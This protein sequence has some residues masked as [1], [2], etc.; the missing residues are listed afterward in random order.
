MNNFLVRVHTDDDQ[1]RDE[2]HN[3]FAQNF[4]SGDPPKEA[5]HESEKWEEA[6]R[7]VLTEH[8]VD[9]YLTPFLIRS[10]EEGDP[11]NCVVCQLDVR[12]GKRG[13]VT[14]N[15]VTTS[16]HVTTP[17]GDARSD[18]RTLLVQLCGSHIYFENMQEEG[19]HVKTNQRGKKFRE[20]KIKNRD[21]LLLHG[22]CNY[23][24][25]KGL[26][27][28]IR[29]NKQDLESALNK[30]EGSFFL[31]YIDY[32]DEQA[33][34][35][36][37]NDAW[38]MKSV[39]FFYE[40]SSVLLTNS[41]GLFI[42]HHFNFTKGDGINYLFDNSS[43][44]GELNLVHHDGVFRTDDE[45]LPKWSGSPRR[46][47]Q[48]EQGNIPPQSII[49]DKVG[50]QI[51]P[52]HI[53]SVNIFEKGKITLNKITKRNSIYTK[54]TDWSNDHLSVEENFHRICNFVEG[55][56]FT[57]SGYREEWALLK[58]TIQ[59]SVK[60]YIHGDADKRRDAQTML[61]N[62]FVQTYMKLLRGVIERK[63]EEVFPNT[64]DQSE[65]G[66]NHLN[67]AGEN[68]KFTENFMQNVP[69]RVECNQRE[70]KDKSVGILF[71]GGI[72][73][74]LLALTTI[75]SYFSRYTDG[76]VELVN[77]CFD[78]NAV[79]RYT[80]LISY[81]QIVKLHPEH[82][83]RLV[84][85]DVSAEDLLKYERIIFSLM[86]PN[87]T[88]M[89]FNISAAFFFA[90]L[91]RGVLFPRSFF[92]R[93]EW[94][95]IKGRAS[96]AL[97][98]P[99]GN[100]A[101]ATFTESTV[102]DATVIKATGTDATVAKS[103]CRVCQFVMS[104]KCVHR[105][106]SVCCR[107]LRY[108]YRRELSQ[109]ASSQTPSQTPRSGDIYQIE[110]DANKG[111]K[112][113][114]LIVKKKKVLINFELFAEC[115]AH[116][117]RMYDYELIDSL[118]RDFNRELGKRELHE[119]EECNIEQAQPNGN[120]PSRVDMLRDT[121]HSNFIDQFVAKHAEN[122]PQKFEQI[123]RLFYVKS[124]KKGHHGTSVDD[125]KKEKL[126]ID[127][128]ES[129]QKEETLN[130]L[131]RDLYQSCTASHSIAEE[132][133]Y[134]C[135]H[136][137]LII[138][139]GADELFGGYYRQN[140]R[141]PAKRESKQKTHFKKNEMIKDVRRIWMRNLYRD[142]RILCFTSF[143]DKVLFYPYLDMNL[144]DFLFSVSFYM[145][146]APLGG[147][148]QTQGEPSFPKS[149]AKGEPSNVGC[150]SV[151]L[152][153]CSSIYEFIRTHKVSKWVLRM[154]LFFSHCKELMLFKKKAIQFG[155]KSKNVQMYMREWISREA[156]KLTGGEIP[157][158]EIP[159][160]DTHASSEWVLP[161]DK[162]KGTDRY[163]LL[164]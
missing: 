22:S 75:R 57:H 162:K 132:G 103:K 25:V 38:G 61:N 44:D 160:G 34:I 144:V 115:A 67:G 11:Y 131:K 53:Y 100:G 16:N 47:S 30:L 19:F 8:Y 130:Y 51:S 147:L 93:P 20:Y 133:S 119:E 161:S 106:C 3:Q 92:Q 81:E 78:D 155:S 95:Y 46:G 98:V 65:V 21:V 114:Y 15:D 134:E 4:V 137:L 149:V 66:K 108:V 39:M 18:E 141:Q 153:E 154:G 49:N 14:C 17:K 102:I 56:Y 148:A 111:D 23:T 135:K 101:E 13:L 116:K 64:E 52:Y 79:D 35:Y 109:G 37:C 112:S 125:Q 59:E 29:K 1:I 55:I 143:S 62:C 91:G 97:N 156:G 96:P 5:P 150:L 12:F 27:N 105:C 113:L 164:S 85:V 84:F 124:K 127:V 82:D 42:H 145:I 31:L 7:Y 99:N 6:P 83:I 94:A 152:D 2:L 121:R 88:T 107:K 43:V 28:Y 120:A 70:G 74:T 71:S 151:N 50:T 138:G 69:F 73:S 32:S 33:N 63:I 77:V 72:D 86:S 68:E 163:T 157:M 10:D 9:T 142:D 117:E 104:S 26:Y 24:D 158:G 159:V 128:D 58:R 36:F 122:D 126:F 90:N 45:V 146:E 118:F 48:Q 40:Q 110:H 87:S 41:Y 80:S 129:P 139:S 54:Y 136:H 76:Y 60:H 89:D 140:N 123:K